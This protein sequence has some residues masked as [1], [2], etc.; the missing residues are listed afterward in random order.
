[1]DLL[2]AVILICAVAPAA[3]LALFGLV[4]LISRWVGPPEPDPAA[5]DP[6]TLGDVFAGVPEPATTAEAIHQGFTGQTC[7]FCGSRKV[8]TAHEA[9]WPGGYECAAC[10]ETWGGTE[11]RHLQQW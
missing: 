10:G 2:R 7:R 8:M 6:R 4:M 9:V 11:N 5:Y 1:M 3:G